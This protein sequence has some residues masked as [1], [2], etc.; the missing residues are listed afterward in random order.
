LCKSQYLIIYAVIVIGII[1]VLWNQTI[2]GRNMY[3]IGGNLEAATVSG[4]SVIKYLLIVY[5]LAGLL[6][7]FAGVLEAG[8][9]GSAT[10]NTGN[11]YELDAIAA[12]VVGGVSTSGGIGSVSGVVTIVVTIVNYF[13]PST[14]QTELLI[15]YTSPPYLQ[16][17]YFF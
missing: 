10:N 17:P 12:C 6:Y 3:A 15:L 8:R 5:T 14:N 4:V 2:L 13:L 16:I 11:M 1:W 7:G 9:V